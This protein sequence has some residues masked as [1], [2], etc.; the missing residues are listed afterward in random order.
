MDS[1][2]LFLDNLLNGSFY[3]WSKKTNSKKIKKK[4]KAKNDWSIEDE[5][6][7]TWKTR[8]YNGYDVANTIP[9]DDPTEELNRRK[10]T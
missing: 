1:E 6:I 10:Y 2:K 5:K 4:N 8:W 7:Y 3:N 9:K